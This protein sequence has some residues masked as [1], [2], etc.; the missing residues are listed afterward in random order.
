MKKKYLQLCPW[1]FNNGK[2]FDI[3]QFNDFQKKEQRWA[4]SLWLF[5][6]Y[7]TII[8][9][10]ILVFSIVLPRRRK[11]VKAMNLLGIADAD[12]KAAL[13]HLENGTCAYQPSNEEREKWL[14]YLNSNETQIQ[15]TKTVKKPKTMLVWGIIL[16]VICAIFIVNALAGN[17]ELGEG[18]SIIPTLV[19]V[20]F[21]LRRWDVALIA[22]NKAK[23]K[24]DA[25]TYSF[26]LQ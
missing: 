14:Q 25:R 20:W 9:G 22:S 19:F 12:V 8:I 15:E 5:A 23:R 26:I 18:E 4:D 7:I 2:N 21:C 17:L 3:E 6:W 13:A 10:M 1:H 16:L 11:A 24:L